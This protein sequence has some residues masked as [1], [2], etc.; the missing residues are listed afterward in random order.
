MAKWIYNL[1]DTD[2]W[3][4]TSD[5]GWIV[6]HSYNVYGPLLC[7]ATTILYE[8]TPD[9]PERDMW[10][11]IIEKYKVTGLWT[12][13]TG[14]RGLMRLGLEEAKKHNLS[15][16]K[17]VFSAGEL[18][19][20][21]AWEWM[22]KEVFED[23]IPVIDHMWQTETAGP[24]VGNPY[25]ISL[26]P[27]KP[28]SAGIPVPGVIGDV[29]DENTGEPQTLNKKGVFVI[30]KPFPGL[31]PTLYND[32]SR[33]LSEYWE[34]TEKLKGVY[35][36]GDAASKDEDGYIFFAGRADEVIKISGHRIGTVE[37]ESVLV[38]HPAV[39]EA[40]VS[41]VPD[42]LRGEVA[43]AFV[44]LKPGYKP[45][46]ELKNELKEHIRNLMGSIVVIKD[47][48]FVNMLPK[49]RS[50]KIMRRVMKRLWTGI[51]LGDISTIEEEASVEE[52]KEAI[53]KIKKQ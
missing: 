24:I 16:V 53:E 46:E 52:I 11:K 31:T 3:F 38:S 2:I 34:R 1:Q 9:Y 18:L 35:F 8:G 40:G 5:I 19:N 23:K 48:E 29:V 21:A 7:G 33:Y 36:T 45:T 44:V 50:G 49:T 17:R 13:P 41:G 47:I 4:C 37:I 27:I 15:S 20:P 42:E 51:E 6:G 14:I 32:H 28:G 10:W 25:G 30:R 12:S 43:C 39:V 26:I 22:Q